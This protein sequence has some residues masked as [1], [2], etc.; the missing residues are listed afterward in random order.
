M[1]APL[2]SVVL[3]T[4]KRPERLRRAVRSVTQQTYDNIELLV[5]DDCSPTPAAETLDAGDVDGIDVTHIRHEVNRGANQARNTGIEHA[6]GK[7]V[8]FL[9]D[10][11]EWLSEKIQRQVDCFRRSGPDVGLVYTGSKFIHGDYTRTEIFE[12]RGDVTKAILLGKSFGQ[13]STYLVR[14]DV[15]EQ[16]GLPDGDFPSWQDRDWLLR[17]S[18][19]CAFEHVPEALT[20]RWCD[21][22]H[23]RISDNFA[24]KRDVSYPL[25]IEKHRDLAASYGWQ[26]ERKFIASMSEILGRAALEHGYYQDARKYLLKAVYYYP[27]PAERVIYALV[28]LGGKSTYEPLSRLTRSV[29]GLRDELSGENEIETAAPSQN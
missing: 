28:A 14:N 23:D 24:E 15:I 18:R 9:D 19:Y 29:H 21:D 1:S 13:F 2:V 16:A 11:D 26:C 10:D 4:Y 12:E 20:I 25:F 3:P 7:Y 6:Q 8:A 5:V 22:E 27:F 17:L